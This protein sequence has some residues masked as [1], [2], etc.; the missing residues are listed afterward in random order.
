MEAA[1]KKPKRNRSQVI[2]VNNSRDGVI[3][4]EEM[5]ESEKGPE[6]TS[7]LGWLDWDL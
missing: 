5:G 1:G 4:H 3:N 6:E 2:S 7:V